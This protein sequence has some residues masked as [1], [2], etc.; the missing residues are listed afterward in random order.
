MPAFSTAIV[1]SISNF[2]RTTSPYSSAFSWLCGRHQRPAN[3]PCKI[4]FRNTV[5]GGS[6]GPI[7][8]QCVYSHMRC[9]MVLQ[10]EFALKSIH[11]SA[12]LK[13]YLWRAQYVTRNTANLTP[14]L[15]IPHIIPYIRSSSGKRS[16]LHSNIYENRGATRGN[17]AT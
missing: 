4:P 11:R 17:N 10:P 9:A 16:N 8:F 12:E 3:H 15:T 1:C 13:S 5:M 7:V 6:R 14:P 2:F